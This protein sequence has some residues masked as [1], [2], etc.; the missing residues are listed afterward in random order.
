MDQDSGGGLVLVTGSIH[1]HC[2]CCHCA[3]V[4]G[5][6]ACIDIIPCYNVNFLS[7][8]TIPIFDKIGRKR[9][10]WMLLSLITGS[11]AESFS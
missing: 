2:F 9:S 4:C 8:Q 6:Y 5:V 1:E 7:A 3:R 10:L 11:C